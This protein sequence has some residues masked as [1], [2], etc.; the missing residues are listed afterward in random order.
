MP[1]TTTGSM[2]KRDRGVRCE[3]CR[4]YKP[5]AMR[6]HNGQYICTDCEPRTLELI[7]PVEPPKEG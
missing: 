2:D 6:D 3:R 5:I 1:I 4:Q 7:R